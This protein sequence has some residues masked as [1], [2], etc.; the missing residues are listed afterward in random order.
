MT[1]DKIYL[2]AGNR[3][4]LTGI[5]SN[6][7]FVCM[8]DIDALMAGTALFPCSVKGVEYQLSRSEISAAKQIAVN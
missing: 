4:L 5:A 1:R 3:I 6:P 2:K 8:I 7:A